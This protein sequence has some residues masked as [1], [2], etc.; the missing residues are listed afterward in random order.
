MGFNCSAHPLS[1]AHLHQTQTLHTWICCTSPGL[2]QSPQ[3]LAVGAELYYLIYLFIIYLLFIL[4][5]HSPGTAQGTGGSGGQEGQPMA[6]GLVPSAPEGH[7]WAG[8]VPLQLS[9][10][11]RVCSEE[12]EVDIKTSSSLCEKKLL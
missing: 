10:S 3:I 6:R 11:S 8:T 5:Q 1:I 12:K 4:P 9:F 2:S 7:H